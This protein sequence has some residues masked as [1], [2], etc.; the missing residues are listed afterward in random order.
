M[1]V[2]EIV[3]DF[4]NRMVGLDKDGNFI[5]KGGGIMS[6]A[7]GSIV[8]ATA[9]TL[10]VTQAAHAGR[11]VTLNRAAGIA[12]TLPAATGTG[13][14]YRFFIGTT[15]TSNTTTITRAGSDTMFGT[16][17]ICNDTDASVSGFEA[18]GSSVITMNGTT[19]GGIKGTMITLIDV[20]SATWYVEVV[21]SATGSEATPFS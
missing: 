11:V 12:V 18:A 21:G 6:D 7:A 16:A 17:I 15:V 2:A 19:T 10:A 8:N 9:A 1:A 5:V 3:T 13:A 14:E 20:A 4:F